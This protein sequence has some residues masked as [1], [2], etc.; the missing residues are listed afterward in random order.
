MIQLLNLL[1]SKFAVSVLIILLFS[2]GFIVI[3]A[4]SRP[5]QTT[6][7][8]PGYLDNENSDRDSDGL[9][10]AIEKIYGTN[11]D[12]SDTDGDGVSDRQEIANNTDPLKFGS[13]SLQENEALNKNLTVQYFSWL[14]ES[15][16]ISSQTLD[17]QLVK[18]F[19]ETKE[20]D[21]PI[22]SPVPQN[23]LNIKESLTSQE[24]RAYLS[25]LD[26]TKLPLSLY[27]YT[28]EETSYINT[29]NTSIA[30]MNLQE[31]ITAVNAAYTTLDG[32]V[33]PADNS[34]QHSLWL[35]QLLTLKNE[36]VTAQ[37]TSPNDPV[38]KEKTRLVAETLSEE[39]LPFNPDADVFWDPEAFNK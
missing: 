1:K 6:N 22:L 14:A 11:P 10:D 7:L 23:T 35:S 29:E 25:A 18:E 37:N 13:S 17:N 8:P 20:L 34:Q 26:G 2:I 39:L 36:L 33:I 38:L 21:K 12:N 9:T 16:H 31:L 4:I 3:N 5:P 15:K 32:L 28:Q 27:L 19:I 24:Q 30:P